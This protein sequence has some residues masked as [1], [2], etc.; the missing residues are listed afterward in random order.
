VEG[1]SPVLSSSLLWHSAWL[2]WQQAAR[3]FDFV[4]LSYHLDPQAI[5]WVNRAFLCECQLTGRCLLS[6]RC[7]LNPRGYA[8]LPMIRGFNFHQW[9]TTGQNT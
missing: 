3:F 7:S 4:F 1:I 9:L 6:I 2:R 8:A 5:A